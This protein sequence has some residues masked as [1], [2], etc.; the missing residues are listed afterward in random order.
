MKR[1]TLTVTALVFCITSL[2]AH[3]GMW[4]PSLLKKYNIEE[5]QRMGFRLTAEDIYDV[6]HASMKDA[7]V[8]FGG[9]CTGELI[10]GEGLLITNHHCGRGQIQNLSSLAHDYLTDGFWARNKNEELPCPGLKVSFLEYMEDVTEKVLQNTDTIRSASAKS[11]KITEN[12]RAIEKEAQQNGKFIAQVR[13]LFY[14]NQYFL[15]VYK[16][17]I[18]VRLVGA[19]PSAIGNFGGDTDNWIWPR[20]TGDF[21]LFRIYANKENEP[22]T[23]STENIPFKPKKSFTISLKGIKPG[24]F[25][26]V[27]GYPGR[28]SE[29]IT[30]DA[31]DLI[32]NQ[33][34]PDLVGIRDVK[35]DIM[36]RFIKSDP[37]IRIQY[38]AKS[39]GI[40]NSWKKWQGEIMGLKKNDAVN[41]KE[42]FESEFEKWAKNKNLWEDHYSDIFRESDRLYKNYAP[43][44]KASD[45]YNE[46]VN[47]GVEL[48]SLAADLNGFLLPLKN[49]EE[50]TPQRKKNIL[51]LATDFFRGYY[52]PLDEQLFTR[53]IPMLT[54]NV[55]E[56][57]LPNHFS[58]LVGHNSPEELLK[59]YYRNSILTDSLKLKLF[60]NENKIS[61]LLKLEKD[62]VMKLY[63]ELSTF[64]NTEIMSKIRPLNIEMGEIMK[65][66]MEGIMRM[67]E[68]KPLYPDANSTLR[69]S[70]GRVEGYQPRDGIT[71]LY[72]ST[73]GGVIEKDNPE[74]YDYNVPDKL[75][76]LYKSKDFGQYEE[77]GKL[78][79]C[80]VASNHTSGGNS[81]SPVVNAEGQ[82]IGI[83]FDRCWEGTMSDIMYDPDICRNIALDIRYALFIIDKFAG[84]GYLLEEMH[85]TE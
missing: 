32:L 39:Y 38:A 29:Y 15:N 12:S 26:M 18:D 3:E 19:P 79:V 44:A 30:S 46:I 78:P 58:M 41:K 65:R 69:V 5:M 61:K 80:F 67:N 17:Y 16:E 64:F 24:D 6:N 48:F 54:A 77:K 42:V 14:G 57:L 35:L 59:K 68:G 9:G 1:L 21:S 56:N 20:H 22:A 52:Q 62:P 25:T 4:I 7:V 45:Y 47:S 81:G 2:I 71:Y 31:V 83:N 63:A 51:R 84:A 23:F 43:L 36:K 34:D 74:I 50:L 73:L 37:G 66:Y 70:Y 55:D 28:T 13:P 11:Q 10:S 72:N 75:K 53:L 40:S 33:R 27:F 60:L 82:L 8:S 49:G 76:E 85:F